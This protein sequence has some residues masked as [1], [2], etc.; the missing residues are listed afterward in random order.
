MSDRRRQSDGGPDHEP[1]V[2]AGAVRAARPTSSLG[3]TRPLSTS[4][5]CSSGIHRAGQDAMPEIADR[6]GQVAGADVDADR[7]A[8]RDVE[9]DLPGR[10]TATLRA[11]LVAPVPSAAM[12]RPRSDR[13]AGSRRSSSTARL[14][15]T[16]AARVCGPLTA[17]RRRSEAWL[18][19]AQTA[20]R[21]HSHGRQLNPIETADCQ[22]VALNRDWISGVSN[23][24]LTNSRTAVIG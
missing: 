7:R 17:G 4:W 8:G 19:A 21:A 10:S 12:P 18:L 22:S 11:G 13:R 6:D 23:N 14:D 3:G 5:P 2:D 1:P 9:S 15:S 20:L 16:S 24:L